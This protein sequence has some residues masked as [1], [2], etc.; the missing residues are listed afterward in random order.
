M[1]E[2]KDRIVRTEKGVLMPTW[3]YIEDFKSFLYQVAAGALP[4]GGLISGVRVH[5]LYSS[6]EIVAATWAAAEVELSPEEGVALFIL[7]KAK[8]HEKRS[9]LRRLFKKGR[10]DEGHSHDAMTD[11]V[12]RV[13]LKGGEPEANAANGFT[14]RYAKRL[15][16]TD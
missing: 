13:L 8:A 10:P 3:E 15:A 4:G 14:E 2:S 9:F 12:L 1:A 16:R 6:K 5:T 11:Y 7:L